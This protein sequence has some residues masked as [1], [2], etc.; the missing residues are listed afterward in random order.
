MISNFVIKF[1]IEEDSRMLSASLPKKPVP[2]DVFLRLCEERRRFP[3]LYKV[4]FQVI[5]F[6]P[7]PNADVSR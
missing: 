2:K 4:E 7:L 6:V 1:V 3:V 5:I